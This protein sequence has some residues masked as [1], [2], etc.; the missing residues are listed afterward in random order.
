M[1]KK[2][3]T[4]SEMLN[5]ALEAISDCLNEKTFSVGVNNVLVNVTAKDYVMLINFS[6]ELD[7]D[8]TIVAFKAGRVTTAGATN[9]R[10]NF[11]KSVSEKVTANDIQQAANTLI[12]GYL[13]ELA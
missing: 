8:R 1:A 5:S 4:K 10:V 9:G 6:L 11:A 12:G 7:E 3:I 13:A 2:V